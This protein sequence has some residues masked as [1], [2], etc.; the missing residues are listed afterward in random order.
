[1]H[2]KVPKEA[3]E[4][5]QACVT[6]QKK[7]GGTSM[8][9]HRSHSLIRLVSP[10]VLLFILAASL[11]VVSSPAQAVSKALMSKPPSFVARLRPLLLAKMQQLRIPG[12]IIY[13][14]NPGQGSWAT[15]LGIGNLASRQPMQVDNS[16]RIASITKTFTATVILQLVDQH[17]LRLDDPVSTYQP[18][19]P[20]GANI[21]IRELLNMTSGLL[22]YYDDEG[23]VQATLADPYKVWQPEELLAI[24]FKHPP[25]FAPG[26]GFHYSNTNYLL[27]GLIMEQLT[28]LSAEK[29]FQRYIFG[30]LG[31]HESNLPP[32]SSSAIPDPHAQGYSYGTNFTGKGPTIN[33][34]DWNPSVAWTAG[35]MISTLHDLKIWAKALA[36]GQLLSAATQKERLTWA[37]CAPAWLGKP[38]CYGLGVSDSGG[39]LGHDG[40]I[41]GFQSWMG[42]QPQTGATII[43]LTN[44]DTAPD[45]SPPADDLAKVI[46]HELFA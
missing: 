16:M 33:V 18:E 4:I 40:T 9:A 25:Y 5:A 27:L 35:S 23:F 39:F 28:H 10:L 46:Q 14:D 19:V 24:A 26:K 43:V 20:N 13:V 34:T 8:K 6:T 3:K 22:D 32:L 42:Y 30:P 37:V 29:A 7:E 17:K 36:T 1:L 45:G 21:T 38:L 2:Q 41:A 31:L 15:G 12:A 11:W 44:L